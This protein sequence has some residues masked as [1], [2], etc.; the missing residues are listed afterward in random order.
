MTGHFEN[1]TV[2]A[3]PLHF[4]CPSR[5]CEGLVFQ[6]RRSCVQYRLVSNLLALNFFSTGCKLTTLPYS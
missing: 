3:A 5:L 2:F 4:L 1:L 6:G